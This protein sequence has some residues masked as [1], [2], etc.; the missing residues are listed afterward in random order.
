VSHYRPIS[1]SHSAA[2]T[3]GLALLLSSCSDLTLPSDD[4]ATLADLLVLS[5]RTNAPAPASRSFW[6]LNSS[7]SV[8]R[9]NHPDNFN[10]LYLE[11]A[12]PAL[13]LASLNGVPLTDDDSVYVTVSPRP[14]SFG[15]TLAPSGIVFSSGAS[16]T[17]TFSFSVYGD[18]AGGSTSALYPTS[19][20]FVAA[21]DIW[22][23]VSVDRWQVAPGSRSPGIDTFMATVESSGQF[24]LAARR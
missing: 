18:A 19:A 5:Q 3:A 7:S 13:S 14:G 23:E 10:T 12:L 1:L 21:L 11:L 8:E 20:D 6:V 16:P 9:F 24:V 17:A 2:A 15:F 22:R 4:L